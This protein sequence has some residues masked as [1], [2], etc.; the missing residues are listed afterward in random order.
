MFTLRYLNRIYASTVY[1]TVISSRLA[2][3]I[4]E[5]STCEP[6]KKKSTFILFNTVGTYT[7]RPL[8]ISSLCNIWT[9]CCTVYVG[10]FL[11]LVARE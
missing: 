5:A 9:T 2:C 1:E 11:Q 6:I 8:Y 7:L 3:V 10:R 4:E